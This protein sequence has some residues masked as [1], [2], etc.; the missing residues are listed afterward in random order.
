MSNEEFI[1]KKDFVEQINKLEKELQI[2]REKNNKN[3]KNINKLAKYIKKSN[4]KNEEK[5]N[6]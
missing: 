3:N 4:N 5:L 2:Q 6:I 1:T